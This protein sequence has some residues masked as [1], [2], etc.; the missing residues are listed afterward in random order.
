MNILIIG[1]A[2]HGK[3]EFAKML[4]VEFQS[5]SEAAL[6]VF[7][8]DV[9]NKN[10]ERKGLDKYKSKKEAFNDRVNHRGEWHKE[11]KWF[12]SPD[13][14]RLAT[15]I[16]SKN[17]CYVGMRCNLEY[18]ACMSKGLFDRVYWVDASKR[19]PLENRDSFNIDFDDSSMICVDNNGSIDDLR[20]AAMVAARDI[21][22]SE[23]A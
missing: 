9:L 16:M 10:R 22:I 3:D 2:R 19:K 13:K 20:L 12:N 17:N 4:G 8:F 15:I 21:K 14:S 6:E 1:H 23:E 5:S 7:L 11:I 18:R